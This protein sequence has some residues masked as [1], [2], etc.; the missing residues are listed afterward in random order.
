MGVFA[1]E[2]KGGPAMTNAPGV[3][4]QTIDGCYAVKKVLCVAADEFVRNT[5]GLSG[6]GVCSFGGFLDLCYVIRRPYF[7][8]ADELYAACLPTN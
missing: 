8:A 1:D 4:T 6:L 5:F 3:A 7:V 2:G